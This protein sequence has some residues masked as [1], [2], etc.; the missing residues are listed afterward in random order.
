MAPLKLHLV[1]TQSLEPTSLS[2]LTFI[3]E[4]SLFYPW[5]HVVWWILNIT[6]T[7]SKY[8]LYKFIIFF[9]LYFL[10][11]YHQPQKVFCMFVVSRYCLFSVTLIILNNN[12]NFYT[13]LRI[14]H[15][16]ILSGSNSVCGKNKIALK[17]N[18]IVKFIVGNLEN[19]FFIQYIQ[20]KC[21]KSQ[22][23]FRKNCITGCL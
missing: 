20:D 15:K 2:K 17:M 18:A 9:C 12:Y 16:M 1:T 6:E 7:K 5:T 21:S 19:I 4:K 13:L 14:G 11:N 8:H 22:L 3:L 10:N 23:R